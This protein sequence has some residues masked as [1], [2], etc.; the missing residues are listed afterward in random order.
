MEVEGCAILV[1]LVYF[2]IGSDGQG[3]ILTSLCLVI[4]ASCETER[5]TEASSLGMIPARA[6]SLSLGKLK[7]PNISCIVAKHFY[8]FFVE[9]I[10]GSSRMSDDVDSSNEELMGKA[11]TDVVSSGSSLGLMYVSSVYLGVESVGT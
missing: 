4:S 10:K 11:S 1:V 5:S 6:R 8:L 3:I 7:C 9:P 2:G